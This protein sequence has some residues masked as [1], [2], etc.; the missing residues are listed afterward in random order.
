IFEYQTLIA[1]LCGM[2]ASNASVYDGA[3][4]AA[5]A[6]LMCRDSTRRKKMLVSLSLHQDVLAVLRTHAHCAGV[7]LV[8][9]PLENGVTDVR[10]VAEHAE[11]AAGLIAPSPNYF[12]LL[13]DTAALAQAIH[14]ARGLMVSYVNPI[15]MGICKKPGALGAG[16]A[17]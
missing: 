2:D 15:A 5:E 16:I 17:V 7:E 12:G 11:G 10:A 3:T 8:E 13:E 4:A 1:R 6:M 14:A 9:I